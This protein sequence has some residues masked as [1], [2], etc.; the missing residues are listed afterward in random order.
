MSLDAVAGAWR[1][2]SFI[3]TDATGDEHHPLGTSP[4]GSLL[5]TP[6]GYLSL[7]FVAGERPCFAGPDLLAG[8]AQEKAAAAASYVSFGGPCRIDGDQV[9]VDVEHSFFPNWT[10]SEQRRRFTL[11]GDTLA[12]ATIAPIPINGADRW[13]RATLTRV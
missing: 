5:I 9:V 7:V 10:G 4:A 1:L 13:G 3:F 2:R 8:S 6:E 11:D 12:L